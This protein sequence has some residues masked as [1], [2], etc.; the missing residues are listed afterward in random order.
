MMT[1][2]RLQA[3]R[4]AL[5]WSQTRAARELGLSRRQYLYLETGEHAIRLTVELA[6]CELTRRAG[7]LSSGPKRPLVR[8]ETPCE[9]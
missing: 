4:T 1:S 3:W 5:A 6:C 8:K 9:T 2:D 7:V